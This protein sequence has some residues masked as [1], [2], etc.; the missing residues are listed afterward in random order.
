MIPS[1]E[2]GGFRLRRRYIRNLKVK[3]PNTTSFPIGDTPY[4]TGTLIRSIMS[5]NLGV[6]VSATLQQ[7]LFHGRSTTILYCSQLSDTGDA[8][9]KPECATCL[10]PIGPSVQVRR[11]VRIAI[12]FLLHRHSHHCNS[13]VGASH[14][15]V[16]VS[17]SE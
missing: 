10:F 15:Q 1:C 16:S 5:R 9:E 17:Q 11:A 13:M 3:F 12:F 2:I 6:Q 4:A 14:L 7:Q 8:A